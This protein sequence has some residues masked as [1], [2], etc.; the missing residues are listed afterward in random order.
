MADDDD[1]PRRKTGHEIGQK[2]D[3]LSVH[4]F[5]ERIALLRA[6]IARLEAAKDLKQR[7][8]DAAGSIFRRAPDT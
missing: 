8:L 5:A 2:L 4:D 7:A 1:A 3:E 6:E